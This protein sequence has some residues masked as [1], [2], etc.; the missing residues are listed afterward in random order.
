MKMFL[1]TA[2]VPLALFTI[3]YGLPRLD[4]D[5]KPMCNTGN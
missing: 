4:R 2:S 3:F 5:G 1:Y